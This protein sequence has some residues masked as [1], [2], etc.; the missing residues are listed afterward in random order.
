MTKVAVLFDP[1]LAGE[2]YFLKAYNAKKAESK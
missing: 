1:A 2:N